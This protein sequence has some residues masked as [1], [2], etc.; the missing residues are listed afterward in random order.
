VN[1]YPDDLEGLLKEIRRVNELRH[2]FWT[3]L[4]RL[5]SKINQYIRFHLEVPRELAKGQGFLKEWETGT[6]IP[7]EDLRKLQH[8]CNIYWEVSQF[9]EEIDR[10]EKDRPRSYPY[11]WPKF[12]PVLDG[13]Q[14][15]V[16]RRR[17]EGRQ[18]KYCSVQCKN[19]AHS[20]QY[21]RDHPE[22]KEL[23]N[24]KYLKE[25]YESE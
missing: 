15:I 11:A 21:R 10:R 13:K 18:R 6:K 23:A 22:E 9:E 3:H 12:D 1:E 20:R 17:L 5:K 8:E 2:E 25:C 14:C 4:R 7:L 19:M 16:C 24:L